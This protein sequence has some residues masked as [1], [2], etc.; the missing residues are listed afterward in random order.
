MSSLRFAPGFT[1]VFGLSL[2]CGL[3]ASTAEASELRFST[4]GKGGVVATGNTLGLSK[5][6][7]AN[8][9]GVGDSIGTFI[10]LDEQLVDDF[11]ANEGNPW[12]MSTT[13]D[14]TLNGST[15]VLTLPDESVGLE[16]AYAELVWSGSYLYGSE[17]V[18]AA[19][20]TP[21]FLA[22]NGDEIEVVPDPT[23]AVTL[24]QV[25]GQGFAINY[26]MRSA[27]VTAFVAEHLGTTYSVSGVPATQD[28]MIEQLNA[29]GWTLVV[30]YRASDSPTRNLSVF[31]GGQFVDEDTTEDYEVAG[32]CTPPQGTVEG[33]VVISAVEGDANR[34]GD[35]LQIAEGS[36]GPFATLSG[37][38]NPVDNFF[39]SQINGPD[40]ELDLGGSFGDLN[41]DAFAG[42]NTVGGRQSWDVTKIPLSSSAGQLS[43]GQTT[44]VLR[45]VTTGDSFMPT[46]AALEIDVNSPDFEGGTVVDVSPAAVAIGEQATITIEMA[47]GGGVIATDLVFTAPL[48][49]GLELVGFEIDGAAG[50]IHGNPV[51]TADLVSGVDLG[52]VD[53]GEG[54]TITMVVEAVEAPAAPQGWLIPA[55]WSYDYVSCVGEDPLDEQSFAH[56]QLGFV[57]DRPGDGDAGDGDGDD[58]GDGDGDEPG[59]GDGDG[60]GS[61]EED[62]ESGDDGNAEGLGEGDT[63]ETAGDDLGFGDRETHDGCNCATT[64]SRSPIAAFGLLALLGLVRRRNR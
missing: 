22:A 37:P 32:F 42:I 38:N 49:Q 10:S 21:V 44:A 3:L 28:Y 45:A 54:H 64:P 59:D 23:T 41:H 48:E 52:D 57:E 50:D 26:Y 6:P 2:A 61:G 60:D 7:A 14:W 51:S 19:L 15:A 35:T 8:G 12:P 43:A 27:E 4:T 16:I 58:P 20:D 9:P 47:N 24:S 13:A 36:N 63:G 1:F 46:L 39:A 17:N 55:G 31:V 34:T 40:G 56:A 53:A 30:V 18:S 25:S 5:Q 62:G 11:P 33:A 29:A